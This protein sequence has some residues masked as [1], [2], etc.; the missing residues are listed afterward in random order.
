[1]SQQQYIE[2]VLERFKMSQAKL[3]SSPLLNHFKL[4]RKHDLSTD[5]EKEDMNNISYVSA[6]GSLMYVMVCTRLDITHVV[7]I[8]T[9][10]M[11]NQEKQHWEAI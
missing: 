11:S 1:M 6:I 5:K 4:S 3:V 9:R 8:V 7:G 10:F 2:K